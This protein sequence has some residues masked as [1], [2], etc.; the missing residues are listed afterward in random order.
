MMRVSRFGLSHKSASI[1]YLK[2]SRSLV[3]PGY[4]V[5]PPSDS[6]LRH[7][8]DYL[9]DPLSIPENQQGGNRHDVEFARSAGILIRVQFP[10]RHLPLVLLRKPINYGGD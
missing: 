2:L 5:I 1:M 3:K 6:R 7:R 9:V 8:P 10:E 4:T